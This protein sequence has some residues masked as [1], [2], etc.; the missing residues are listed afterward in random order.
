MCI[1]CHEL[2][3]SSDGQCL[4]C[5]S[6]NCV[7]IVPFMDYMKK[8]IKIRNGLYV[9]DEILKRYRFTNVKR[10]WDPGSVYVV[11]ELCFFALEVCKTALRHLFLCLTKM[12]AFLR[13]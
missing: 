11:A 12:P 4:C 9:E 5:G 13:K 1:K 2:Q 10:K 6:R 8:R 7:D 3:Y